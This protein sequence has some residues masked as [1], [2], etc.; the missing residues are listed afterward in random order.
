[1]AA[2]SNQGNLPASCVFACPV[3]CKETIELINAHLLVRLRI[4]ALWLSAICIIGLFTAHIVYAFQF[5]GKTLV[6]PDRELVWLIV[7]APWCCEGLV[8]ILGA[9]KK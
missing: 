5:P 9:V 6:M 4:G 7:L 2:S 1:M 3:H 8:N